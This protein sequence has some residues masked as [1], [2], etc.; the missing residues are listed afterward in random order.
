MRTIWKFTLQPECSIEMPSGAEVLSV[1]E[2]GETICLWALVDPEATVE[3]R[4]FVVLGTGHSVPDQPLRFLG[5]A[6]LAGG[7]FVFHV[8]EEV[9]P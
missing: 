4:R 3:M 1:R 9:V 7:A 6:H 8:F 2:Q 5:T